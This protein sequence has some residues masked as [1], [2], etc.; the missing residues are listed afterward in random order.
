M[1]KTKVMSLK[2]VLA[3][4]KMVPCTEEWCKS[5][6]A[7]LRKQSKLKKTAN[8]AF[9]TAYASEKLVALHTE[10]KHFLNIT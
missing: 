4:M 8:I 6:Q 1:P 5:V 9:N 7:E 3:E 2:E 10:I